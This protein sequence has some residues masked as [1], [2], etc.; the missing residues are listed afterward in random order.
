VHTTLFPIPHLYLNHLQ[1]GWW[2]K[3][4]RDQSPKTLESRKPNSRMI[5]TVRFWLGLCRF[6]HILCIRL[7][8]ILWAINRA[9]RAPREGGIHNI[10][11]MR[12]KLQGYEFFREVLG[13]PR[14][15]VAPMVDQSELVS[16]VMSDIDVPGLTVDRMQAWRTLSRR[17]G[18][19]VNC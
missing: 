4:D 13:S 8:K 15:I 16:D 19:Q 2:S 18:A 14:Y 1:C 7:V 10:I 5:H 6:Y 12:R 9:L 11:P 3:G 17:Y